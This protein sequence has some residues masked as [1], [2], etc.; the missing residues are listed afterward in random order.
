MRRSLITAALVLGLVAAACSSSSS[1]AAPPG[2]TA[3]AAATTGAGA[4]DATTADTTT[5]TAAAVTTVPVN[6][7]TT[8]APSTLDPLS[9]ATKYT[10]PGSFP[11]GI[12]K[13]ALPGGAEVVVYY[14]AV[15][16]TTG[17]YTYDAR[18]YTAA[19]VKALLTADLPATFTFDATLDAPAAAGFHPVALYS[20]GF[21]GFDLVSSDL[22][23]QLASWGVIVAA[24]EHHSRDL[25]AATSFKLGDQAD[26]VGEL[27]G[28]IDLLEGENDRAGALLQGHVASNEI[29]AIGHSAGGGT[30]LRAAA[31]A[32]IDA[33]VSLA[34]GALANRDPVTSTT[35]APPPMPAKPSLFVA[36]K[37][38]NVVSWETVTKPAYDQAPSPSE[39]WVIDGVGHVGFTDL[40]A[41]A[42]GAGIIGV[43]E[44]SGL[45]PFLDANPGFR[46]LGSDGCHPPALPVE[47]TWPIIHQVVTAF[48]LGQFQTLPI[49][50]TPE[51]APGVA[52]AYDVPVVIEQK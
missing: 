52:A 23:R 12:T 13:L 19:S 30:V 28:T 5:T 33:Y 34:S 46:A 16:G 10:G 7:E 11:V 9:V 47:Q 50:S 41:M 44:A 17:T 49:S 51:L 36:G 2:G 24:P 20:H 15:E 39:L 25:D 26:A 32:R 38:D 6:D 8:A 27:L 4:P 18:D 35:G 14:P 40:C 22:M 42:G 3:A 37:L 48:V 21:S 45:G 43:A 1:D 29:V 31:D